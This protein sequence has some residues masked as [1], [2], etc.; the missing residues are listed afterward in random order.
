MDKLRLGIVIP[1]YTIPAWAAR[2]IEKL[3]SLKTAEIALVIQ[4]SEQREQGGLYKT[5]LKIDRRLFRPAPNAWEDK[6]MADML[7]GIPVMQAGGQETFQRL[8]SFRLDIIVN[9]SLIEFPQ[10]FLENSR[11][12]VWTLHDGQS[13]FV[14]DSPLGWCE[15]FEGQFTST[16][17]VEIA[18]RD[19]SQ[20]LIAQAVIASDMQSLS[21]NQNGIL[22][23][24]A[25]MLPYAVSQLSARGEADFL[26]TA[27]PVETVPYKVPS[28]AQS[29]LFFAKQVWEKLTGKIR[30][31]FERDQ[32]GLLLKKGAHTSLTWDGFQQVL[33]PLDRFWA[34]PFMVEREGKP[35]LFIEE[36]LYK[37]HRGTINCLELDGEGNII[38][39]QV[40]LDRPYH[41]SYPFIFE[42]RGEIYM[43]P[44]TG[45]NLSVELYRC[46][47]FPDQWVLH[48]TLLR[49]VRAVDST[50]IDYLGKWWLFVTVAEH[51]NSTWDSLHIY[52]ADDPLSDNWTPHPR[53]PIISDVSSARMAGR[54]FRLNGSLMRPSQDSTR[55]YGY[56]LNLYRITTLTTT[57]YAETRVDRLEP[58]QGSDIQAIHTFNFSQNW[59][60]MDLTV[61]RKK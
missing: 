2:L 35:Y 41:L 46:T 50:L 30:K 58:P 43:M 5:H 56:A 60:V 28:P 29:L 4:A 27:S 37:T 24:A 54:I 12:G 57:D 23:K 21:R 15:P 49:D 14:I 13:R 25:V 9:L 32:W 8:P 61:R 44:E 31:R 40:V 10:T 52:Y 33:A 19:Q 20:Q 7:A 47:R 1:S 51:G 34:D 26:S 17:A 55:R 22:W 6:K 3:A 45:K 11:F 18:R 59:T 38:K 39:N 53:N 36:L 48:K 16:C 42:H